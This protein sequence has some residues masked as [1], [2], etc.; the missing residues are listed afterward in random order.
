[1]RALVTT[2]VALLAHPAWAASPLHSAQQE[3]ALLARLEATE[4]DGSLVEICK[5]GLTNWEGDVCCPG[6]CTQCGG[7]GCLKDDSGTN[8][9]CIDEIHESN[10][11]C[12]SASDVKC[13]MP[14]TCAEDKCLLECPYNRGCEAVWER[15]GWN[16][17][18]KHDFDE[19]M[20]SA[21]ETA[22]AVARGYRLQV[23][24]PA[25]ERFVELCKVGLTNWAGDVCCPGSCKQCGGAGASGACLV[26]QIHASSK[27]CKSASDVSC[28]MPKTCAEDQCLLECPYNRKCEEVWQRRGWKTMKEVDWKRDN[29][30][31]EDPSPDLAKQRVGVQNPAAS[32]GTAS[33][34]SA[35]PTSAS[36][37]SASASSAKDG[38]QGEGEYTFGADGWESAGGRTPAEARKRLD[39]KAPV[40]RPL[41]EAEKEAKEQAEADAK[42]W[43]EYDAKKEA[44]AKRREADAEAKAETEADAKA[45]AKADAQAAA[46]AEAEAEAEAEA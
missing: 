45:V 23:S 33:H 10:K 41:T 24:R 32:R 38:A 37:T 26:D 8:D 28:I 25:D 29:G 18:Q 36:P 4:N 12:S 9:C 42:A 20:I 21:P 7:D 19:G 35:S 2:A 31:L 11:V 44:E 6:S 13:L 15:R 30:R 40:A 3:K 43:A 1:M 14:K 39:A 27:V 16:R 5:D 22:P 46:Q 17:P 34:T